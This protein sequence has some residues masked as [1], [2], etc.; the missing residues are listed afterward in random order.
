MQ[1]QASHAHRMPTWDYGKWQTPAGNANPRT[2]VPMAFLEKGAAID[3]LAELYRAAG[4]WIEP[5][6]LDRQGGEAAL[7][8]E[9]LWRHGLLWGAV[10]SMLLARHPDLLRQTSLVAVDGTVMSTPAEVRVLNAVLGMDPLTPAEARFRIKLCLADI[11]KELL[12]SDLLPP[13]LEPALAMWLRWRASSW[14]FGRSFPTCQK[15][16]A[17]CPCCRSGSPCSAARHLNGTWD[18]TSRS[19]PFRPPSISRSVHPGI[20]K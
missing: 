14:G 13:E 20:P 8:R 17:D 10:K 9:S 1:T 18:A 19:S 6:E 2:T 15:W 3:R 11:G 7:I 4:R 12:P 16:R 5:R